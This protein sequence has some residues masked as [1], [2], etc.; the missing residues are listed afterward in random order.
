MVAAGATVLMAASEENLLNETGN[1]ITHLVNQSTCS[2]YNEIRCKR[3]IESSVKGDVATCSSNIIEKKHRSLI[4]E[5]NGKI[6]SKVQSKE[7]CKNLTSCKTTPIR[8]TR[9]SRLRAA[10]IV[11][12]SDVTLSSKRLLGSEVPG[13][14]RHSL[15][16]KQKNST[17]LDGGIMNSVKERDKNY[18]RKS[19]LNRSRHVEATPTDHLS[20][21]ESSERRSRRQSF[22]QDPVTEMVSS[23]ADSCDNRQ[24]ASPRR[25]YTNSKV[26]LSKTCPSSSVAT[27]KR[28][29]ARQQ[30]SDVGDSEISRRVDV[31]TAL[32]RATIERVERLASTTMSCTNNSPENVHSVA[33]K[34]PVSPKKSTVS[35]H[36]P[37]SIL[38]HKAIDGEEGDRQASSSGSSHTPSPVTFSPSVT[39]PISRKK[40]G[41]LKK[42]SSLDENEILRRRSCSPD[43]SFA[44]NI[45]SEFRPI[46]KNQRRSSLDEIVK[47]DQSPDQQLASILKR[48]SSREDDREFHRSALGSPEPQSIL[49]RK[50]ANSVRV[51]SGNH[52]ATNHHVTSDAASANASESTIAC[53]STSLISDGLEGSEVRPI[54]KKKYGRE[55]FIGGDV[56]SLEPR[57]ILKKKSSTESDEH[58]HDRPKKTILKSS[59][60][61]SYEEGG[62]EAESISPRKLSALKN[63]TTEVESVRPILKQTGGG[64]GGG[65]GN[66]YHEDARDQAADSFLR[67]RAQ[68]VG[69]V[70][71]ANSDDCAESIRVLAKRRSLESSS[72]IDVSRTS[73]IPRRCLTTDRPS[74]ISYMTDSSGVIKESELLCEEFSKT[75]ANDTSAMEEKNKADSRAH[76][77]KIGADGANDCD[78]MGTLGQA[79]DRKETVEDAQRDYEDYTTV[80][81]SNSVSKMT[82]YFKTL[83]EKV[84]TAAAENCSQHLVTQRLSYG[85]QRY[86]ERK[87]QCSERFNTQPVTFQEVREAV[88]QNQ[89]NAALSV[90][91]TPD[92]EPEPSKL[93]LAERVR[94]F[95]QKIATT[96]TAAM[97]V[98]YPEKL[99]QK[100][101]PSTRYKTQPVTS[102]EVEVASRL[103]SLNA[104]HQTQTSNVEGC[105]NE[106]QKAFTTSLTSSLTIMSQHDLPKSILKSSTGYMQNL[107]CAKNFEPSG[108]KLVKS[109]LKRECEDSEQSA[110]T[111]PSCDVY[112]RSIL[113]SNPCFKSGQTVNV[114][115]VA[116]SKSERGACGN[117]KQNL[118][119]EIVK[120]CEK[121]NSSNGMTNIT[122]HNLQLYSRDDTCTIA[123]KD[124]QENEATVPSH[125]TAIFW[126]EEI[127]SDR[128]KCKI[129]TISS[130]V[131]RKNSDK[132]RDNALAAKP[133]RPLDGSGNNNDDEDKYCNNGSDDQGKDGDEGGKKE[134]AKQDDDDDN[135]RA[136]SS[137]ADRQ[138]QRAVTNEKRVA[139]HGLPSPERCR[140]ATQVIASIET[141][142]TPSVSI[143]DRLAA[144]RHNGSTNWKQRMAGGRTE[145]S[146]GASS[147]KDL[148]EN[149]TTIKSNVLADCIGKLESAMEGW[150]TRVVTPDA[151]NF[152]VAGKMKVTQSKDVDTPFLSKATANV[153]SQ[154][155]QASR[156]QWLKTRKVCNDGAV[157]TPTSPCKDWSSATRT[158]FSEPVSDDSGEE[159]KTEHVLSPT[160]SVPKMDDETFTSFFS[161]VSLEKC[162]T[163]CL[164]L[165]ENAFNIVAPHS[166]LLVQKRNIRM[167]RRRATSKN[168]LKVLAA[169]TDLRSEY[170]EIHTDVAARMLNSLSVKITKSSSFTVEALAGLASTEDFSTVTLRNVTE[171]GISTNKLQPYKDVMLIL[172]KGRR[173]VQARL[174]EPVAESINSGDNY[175]LVTKSEVFNYVGK[176]SNVIEKTRAAEIALSIQQ[177][178][179]LGCQATQVITIN[180]DKLICTRNQVEKFWHYLGV[181][182]GGRL[183][184]TEAGNP[185]EDELY[186][187]AIIDTNMVYELK[188]EQLVPREKLWGTL[189][190]IEML[191]KNK[192]LVFD[193]GTEMYIWNGKGVSAEK[194]R[195]ATQLATEMWNNGYDYSECVACP[196]DAAR[197]IGNRSNAAPLTKS[198]KSRPEWC[199]LAKLTQ[200]VETI[201]FR[202][203]FLDWPNI[204]AN[205]KARGR[206]DSARQ[207]DG[208]TT[209]HLDDSDDMWLPNTTPVDLVLEGCHLGRGIGCYDNELRKEYV[210]ATTC[211][212]VWYIDEFSHTRLDGSS[213]GQFYSGDSYIVQW[214]YSVTIT[215]RELSGLPSKHSAKG[216]DRSVY[217]I[218][219]G[220]HASLNERGAAALLTVELDSDQR[221]PQVRIVQGHEPAVFLNLF[222]GRMVVHTGKKSEKK[223]EKRWRFYICRGT[224]ESEVFLI[225]IPC[226]TRQ[227]R[228]R[229]SFLL[230]DTKNAKIYIWHGNHSL[231]H[232]RENAIKAANKLKEN[233]PEEAGLS[234]E[235]EVQIYEIQEGSEPEEFNNALGGVNKKLYWSLETTEI[236]DHTPRL[237]HLSSI[238]QKFRATEILCL[239]RADL[240]TPFPFLQDDLYQASQ[241][242][243]FLLDDKNV[244]WIWQGW[245]PDSETEDQS[246]T[247]TVRWQ[248]ERRAAMTIAIRYWRKTRS[249]QTTNF[250]IY[251][252]WAGLEPLQFINLFPEWTYRDDV[253]ELNMEDGRNPGEVLTA[254]NEL[255]RLTQSTYPPAQLLQRPLPDG[256]DPTRLELYLSQQHFQELFGMSK[257]EFQQLPVWKQVNL[258]KE[259]GL[260]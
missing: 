1:G 200:H 89:R 125:K 227:L 20:E 100:R 66:R 128:T 141:S 179:D 139:Q 124:A 2:Q 99:T 115:D 146:C 84:N 19:Y 120:F 51:N 11:S 39:E 170:T 123:F 73:T 260:F 166:E 185:D 240:T 90:A 22:K 104:N 168:P 38:K 48:K 44:D 21:A 70:R 163:E 8:E 196:I 113:K 95:D 218:W 140:S 92:D 127:P 103:S 191:D 152:T 204:V 156:S 169:R 186:E 250:P 87:V 136:S 258:K 114:V 195:L 29:I 118:S 7:N 97:N 101:R 177:Q 189:P 233:R 151:I 239:H 32:T 53:T 220:R 80:R 93:S 149:T 129:D 64:G 63:R 30:P 150:K 121:L 65:G 143:A 208:A 256:V 36:A 54:L 171:I 106:S 110:A 52:H 245:W 49:K 58:E 247:K 207:M 4:A 71:S 6:L 157:S 176:Y 37:V 13:T 181:R 16:A 78:A 210:I 226:S 211:V 174:V 26:T 193:F 12:P 57:P 209:V 42:R 175:I 212:M 238:F 10:S 178:K 147:L 167:Q 251:L 155:K 86:R 69:H 75:E 254:E 214:T 79:T 148:K 59:R 217:F 45:Y 25:K 246:G 237:Y 230:L 257:E 158:S 224:L 162:G 154:K 252:V 5:R 253:A 249:T 216:R 223:V 98:A 74:E 107:S 119:S 205:V 180:E 197:V 112:P 33:E 144:L 81:R 28:S 228:S 182:D 17:S 190:K 206:K 173:H 122:Q 88:L 60:K 255:A 108:T 83:Q 198:A 91:G 24:A 133:N 221:V 34:T 160:V 15:F 142:D 77:A 23:P 194:K 159:C 14:Q 94:L 202:E 161:G 62:Y 3:N 117:E 243:L 31:L 50:L 164:D 41:I 219:Q 229:G 61:N 199:L 35:R 201:L 82:Q 111:L 138:V 183:N 222:C 9:T 225:E 188:N 47:R 241:P 55:E 145:E 235:N 172:I 18:K 248:A 134:T 76:L 46:L 242:A 232:I 187:S 203:K 126:N 102:K 43:V 130:S 67:K 153:P 234:K 215:G 213:I 131:A 96:D 135:E 137:L 184:V 40:H 116:A 68:S 105:S 192:I 27:T 85:M 165:D 259:M 72:P 56:L 236:Q 109:M 132:C 244:I 231:R